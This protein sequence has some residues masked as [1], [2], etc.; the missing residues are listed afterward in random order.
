M[1][2]AVPIAD[3]DAPVDQG[4]VPVVMQVLPA[5]ET[6]G[7]E[8]SAVDVARALVQ[9]GWGSLVVSRG[10]PMVREVE[11][12]GATHITLPVHS[13]NPWRMWRN[14]EALQGLIL[15]HGVHIV[16]ARSRAPAWSARAA[17]RSTGSH[18]VTTVHGTYNAGNFLKRRYNAIMVQGERV[19][20][21]SHFTAD[22]AIRMYGAD[23]QRVVP[24]PRGIDVS[25]ID[26]ATVTA[27]R[28]VRLATEWR[29]PDG[30]HVVMLPGRLTRWKGQTV[31]IDAIGRLVAEGLGE[32][33]SLVCLLVGDDQGR[34]SYRAEIEAQAA[35][36]G[37]SGVVHA[38]GH[39]RDMAAAYMLADVVVSASTDPEAFGRVA[40]EAQA[41]GRPV[42]ATDHGATR[43]TVLPG[44]T[45]WLV[46]PGD[47][48]ALADAIRTAL[49]L[50]A[51]QREEMAAVA[52]AHIVD[53]FTVERMCAMT[54]DVY[55]DV[56][57]I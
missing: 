54:L 7:V 48:G 45:G 5:L 22:H 32:G 28:M 8:R 55:A 16:H 2:D 23:P 3:S 4:R 14:V 57:G 29:L 19:I 30:A 40:A 18:F 42:I 17:A 15:K 43:E 25:R 38:V 47:A 26:P 36:L 53:N 10:G 13:K 46:P 50:D 41:M 33:R 39:C 9:A 1:S 12:A 20:A 52:R 44:V 49:S 11:R 24:I 6:G 34:S 51:A 31:L 37:L 27:D 35:R 56:L 21:N